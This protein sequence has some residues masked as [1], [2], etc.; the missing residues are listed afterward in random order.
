MGRREA[1]ADYAAAGKLQAAPT[2]A[3]TQKPLGMADMIRYA[4]GG[5]ESNQ[6]RGRRTEPGGDYALTSRPAHTWRV[7]SGR[8]EKRSFDRRQGP[9]TQ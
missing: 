2:G 8:R 3:G 5:R 1:R 4:S 9:A 6:P 7:A